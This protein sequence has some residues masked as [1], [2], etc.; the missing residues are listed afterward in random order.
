MLGNVG[1]LF[2]P[3]MRLHHKG[4][5]R[6]AEPYEEAILRDLP[7]KGHKLLV[8]IDSATIRDFEA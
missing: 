8:R 5:G 4:G 1:I 7:Q 2:R 3:L 6:R